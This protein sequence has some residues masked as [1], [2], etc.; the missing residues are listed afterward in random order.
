[1]VV[2]Y[3]RTINCFTQLDAYPMSRIHDL[4][5]KMAKYRIFS[6]I[7]LKSA[8]YQVPL[9]DSE[10]HYTAFEADG[11]LFQFNRVPF[12]LTN[13]V[14]AFQRVMDSIIAESGL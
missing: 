7:D 6:K 10:K 5:H 4:V 12:G 9:R 13:S 11:Q 8:Y 1:M 3:S 14:A 2:D